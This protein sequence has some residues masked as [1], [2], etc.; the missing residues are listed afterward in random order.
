MQG[1]RYYTLISDF[2]MT[3]SA[4]EIDSLFQ[5]RQTLLWLG[6]E[7]KML[8]INSYTHLHP[9]KR[10]EFNP[11][12]FLPSLHLN[13]PDLSCVTQHSDAVQCFT[14]WIPISSRYLA[15]ANGRWLSHWPRLNSNADIKEKLRGSQKWLAGIIS[16]YRGYILAIR[17]NHQMLCIQFYFCDF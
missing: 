5:A 17:K 6:T 11:T 3:V 13:K 10:T 7:K 14:L 2:H 12:S 4:N 1:C 15:S 8:E 9:S 16:F